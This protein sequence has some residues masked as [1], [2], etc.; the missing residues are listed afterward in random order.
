MCLYP[1]TNPNP[2]LTGAKADNYQGTTPCKI[3]SIQKAT[4]TATVLSCNAHSS[5]RQLTVIKLGL[6]T[7]SP[8]LFDMSLK[9]HIVGSILDFL[10]FLAFFIQPFIRDVSS[11]YKPIHHYL[12]ETV[13]KDFRPMEMF[14]SHELLSCLSRYDF[15]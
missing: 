9:N 1:N 11:G 5:T 12:S 14:L 13:L 15:L 8:L 7:I 6:L 2:F 4:S 3:I 10:D